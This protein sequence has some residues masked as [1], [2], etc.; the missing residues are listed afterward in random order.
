MKYSFKVVVLFFVL[1]YA[2][3]AFLFYNFYKNLAIH[4]TKQEAISILNTTKAL[5][6]YIESVQRPLI[7]QLKAE[8]RLAMDFFDPKIFSSSYIVK[9][10]YDILLKDAKV[11]YTYRLASNNPTNPDNQ[12]DPFESKILKEFQS[13]KIKEHFE[14]IEENGTQYFYMALPIG[15][16]KPSCME[17][18]GDPAYA[19]LAMIR[20]YGY[21]NGFYEKVGDTRAFISLKA[22]VSDIVDYHIREFE[23]GGLAMLFTFMIF[24]FMAY[25]FYKQELLIQSK[26]EI[27][28]EN[29]NKLASMGEMISNIAHQWRQPL[30][31]ISSALVNMELRG[32]RGKLTQETVEEK[33]AEVQKQITFMSHTIDDFREFYKP[34]EQKD[35]FSISQ[36]IEHACRIISSTIEKNSIEIEIGIQNDYVVHGS[37]NDLIQVIINLLNNAKDAFVENDISDRRV[38]IKAYIRDGKK[39]LEIEDHA[40]GI[41]ESIKGKIF[42]PYFTTKHPSVGTGIGLHMVKLIIEKR[43]G[44]AIEIHS[45]EGGVRFILVFDTKQ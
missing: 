28:L 8:G 43:Y 40:G 9:N 7:Y 20:R 4:D 35:S 17:C 41:D 33:V 14:I 1:L 44:G 10:T 12:A 19:P 37:R 21:I 13:G 2:V 31:Q 45:I 6:N 5:R 42:D 23:V 3:I 25:L 32:K 30:A 22:P 26:R 27:L 34:Q 29:Q 16:N 36:A 18:H 24:I 15:K 39:I 38:A 11:S